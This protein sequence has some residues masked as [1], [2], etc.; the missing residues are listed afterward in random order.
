MKKFSRHDLPL[1]LALLIYFQLYN[2]STTLT[3]HPHIHLQFATF[4]F[5]T[6]N[7]AALAL[8]NNDS[9]GTHPGILHSTRGYHDAVV[10]GGP[11]YRRLRRVPYVWADRASRV[12]FKLRERGVPVHECP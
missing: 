8:C 9:R 11:G 5:Y 6:D 2:Q 12:P 1:S 10:D 7:L 3:Y 4:I